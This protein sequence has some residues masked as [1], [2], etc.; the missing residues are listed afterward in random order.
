MIKK[1][2]Y[3]IL[4][5]NNEEKGVT[6][7]LPA[8][9]V[10]GCLRE[11]RMRKLIPYLRGYGRES[12]LGPLFKLLEACFEL[13]VPVIMAAIIDRGIAA[14]DIGYILAMGGVLL[15][16]GILGLCSSVTAQYFAARA[17]YG[18][19][20]ALR[21]DLFAHI[22]RLSFARLDELGTASLV[23]R[24]TGDVNQA[25]AG[26]NLVLRL[27][28]R[29]PFIV[30]GALVMA[31][32]INVRIAGVFAVAVPLLSLVIYGVMAA[33]MPIYKKAQ[34]QLDKVALVTRENL[35]GIRVIRAFFRQT[36]EAERFETHSEKLRGFQLLAGRIS[37]LM[38]PLTYVLV[39][40]AIVLILWQGAGQ[41]NAGVLTQGEVIALVNYMTQILLALV[42][43]AQLIVTFTRASAS[44]ARINEVFA[45]SPGMREEKTQTAEPVAGAPRVEME[46]VRF[47]Y[48]GTQTAVLENISFSVKPGETVGIIGGT[49]AG[50]STLVNLIPRFYD[51]RSGTVRVDGVDVRSYPFARLREKMGI[52]PQKAVL[53]RGTIRDNMR[54]RK[55]EATDEEIWRALEIAQAKDVVLSKEGGL[56]A[57]VAQDGRNFSGGQRQRLTI[58]RALVGEPEILILDDSASALDFATDARLRKALAEQTEKMTVFVVSQRVSSVCSA[59]RILVLEDGEAVGMGTHEQLLE[60]C[61]VYREICLS[62]LSKEEVKGA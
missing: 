41:V 43:L 29:S 51:V 54:W 59:D 14:G 1:G 36:D 2:K 42:A 40:G 58:A 45:V 34:K 21:R 27:F 18:F 12:I 15:L 9:E 7:H 25:Q 28:L 60:N 62:Q 31:F 57:W 13:M 46:G 33:G 55:P 23:T 16:L 11:R 49:G 61:E 32:G 48:E 6:L 37:A 8:A 50:K 26:V 24:L 44:A 17:A 35:T 10:R 56:D 19:G 3:A 30:A 38:N 39:N 53:F 47:A 4:L 5:Y 20:T 22:N 52:V